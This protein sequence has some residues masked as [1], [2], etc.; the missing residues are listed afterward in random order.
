[1]PAGRAREPDHGRVHRPSHAV[2][3]SFHSSRAAWPVTITVSGHAASHSAVSG[4]APAPPHRTRFPEH[5]TAGGGRKSW[6]FGSWSAA[7]TESRSTNR[8]DRASSFHQPP[9]PGLVPL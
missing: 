1:D 2:A 9:V 3:R 8:G 4:N 7:N 6:W 5:V